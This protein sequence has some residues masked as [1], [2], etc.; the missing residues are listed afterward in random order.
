MTQKGSSTL[1]LVIVLLLI[2]GGSFYFFKNE[3]NEKAPPE[4]SANYNLQKEVVPFKTS[5]QLFSGNKENSMLIEY[6]EGKDGSKCKKTIYN[7]LGLE[8]TSSDNSEFLRNINC[9]NSMI[10]A[11]EGFKNFSGDNIIFNLLGRDISIYNIPSAKVETLTYELGENQKDYNLMAVDTDLK[12]LLFSKD[13]YSFI[14]QI[15]DYNNKEI[16]NIQPL[17]NLETND[18]ISSYYD[19]ANNGILY[20]RDSAGKEY[21]FTYFDLKT[22]KMRNL[23]SLQK[24]PD[25]GGRDCRGNFLI[26]ETKKLTFT[27][28]CMNLLPKDKNSNSE[29]IL[30]L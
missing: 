30:D 16:F 4:F 18:Q 5:R 21:Q 19:P 8:I 1:V 3:L 13:G 11:L 25:L 23:K 10:L 20:L 29:I 6:E 14:D 26:S 28:D 12:Y 24:N 2:I 7:K 27:G 9:Q 22:K 15:K 17:L